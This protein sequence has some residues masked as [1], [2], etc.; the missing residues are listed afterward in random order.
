MVTQF[1]TA[2]QP[3]AVETYLAPIEK[4]SGLAMKLVYFMSRKM[5][6]KV[7]TPLKVAYSR[8]PQSFTWFSFKISKLD[9]QLELPAE[10]AMLVREQVARLNVC[11]FCIDIGRSFVIKASL[12]EKKFDAIDEYQ[13]SPLFTASDRAALDYVTELTRDK[14]MRPETFARLAEHFSERQICEIAWLVAT[15]H[16]YNMVNIGLNIHSDM[17]CDI[18]KGQKHKER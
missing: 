12:D 8:L 5:F 9:K 1:E 6:G 13:T 14:Q 16:Y 17:L 15:E 10:T 2:V 18:T 7:L 4:P 11:L 3:T